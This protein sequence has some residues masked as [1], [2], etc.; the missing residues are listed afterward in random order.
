[1]QNTIVN[2]VGDGLPQRLPQT[3]YLQGFFRVTVHPRS[4]DPVA[5]RVGGLVLPNVGSKKMLVGTAEKPLPGW[6]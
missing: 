1:M 6:R 2:N 3:L 5:I 4:A